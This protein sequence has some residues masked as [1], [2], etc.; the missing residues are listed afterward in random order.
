MFMRRR[1]RVRQ[2]GERREIFLRY[3]KEVAGA[4]SDINGA[5]RDALYTQLVK[6]A[7][8]ITSDAD[9]KLDD[10]GRK[11]QAEELDLGENVLIVD[12]LDSAAAIN[13]AAAVEPT[14]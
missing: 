10:R 4:V 8:K 2:Q 9:M 7:K 11:L 6:V 14:E 5:E 1:L 3:L 12:P 13:R